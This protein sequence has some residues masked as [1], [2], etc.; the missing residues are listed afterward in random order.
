MGMELE[1]GGVEGGGDRARSSRRPSL[2]SA[3]AAAAA[4]ATAP[5]IH[6]PRPPDS[7]KCGETKPLKVIPNNCLPEIRT[8]SGSAACLIPAWA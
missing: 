5:L 2:R 1:G 6:G 7:G 8:R 4:A 3:A